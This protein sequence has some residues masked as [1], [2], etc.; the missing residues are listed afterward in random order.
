MP[1]KAATSGGVLIALGV[2]VTIVS[3]SQSVTSLIPAFIGA[4]FLILGLLARAKPDLN[5]HLMHAL[6]AI[7]LLAV[8]GSLGSLISRS[9][10]G[11]ALFAQLATTVIAGFLLQQSVMAFKNRSKLTT[12]ES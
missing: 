7:A 8:L 1:K 2:I 3:D 10:T 5:H 11:W 6:A 9:S 12:E 4:V